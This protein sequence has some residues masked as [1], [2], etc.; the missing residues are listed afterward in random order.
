ME[1]NIER[2]KKKFW[3]IFFSP[4]ASCGG[5]NLVKTSLM[6]LLLPKF[7]KQMVLNLKEILPSNQWLFHFAVKSMAVTFYPQNNGCSA[8]PSNR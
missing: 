1:Q 2:P 3:V 4:F 8:L 7:L 5:Y 6:C